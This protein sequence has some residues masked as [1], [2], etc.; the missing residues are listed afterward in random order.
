[1]KCLI[2]SDIHYDL[3]HFDWLAE[4]ASDYDVLIIAG[5]LLD[6]SSPVPPQ[7]Q[8]S[9]V[10]SYLSE[11]KDQTTLIVSS[12]NH[13]LNSR[14][15]NGEKYSKWFSEL[16]KM[17]IVSDGDFYLNETVL[18]TV[19]PWW[20]GPEVKNK[21]ITQLENDSKK[22]R[23]KWIWIY[24]PPPSD[25]PTSW[26]GRR[27]YGDDDLLDWIEK[28]CPDIVLGGHIHQAPFSEDGSWVDQVGSTL[29]FNP[30]KQIGP[31]P[32]HIILD[33]KHTEAVWFSIYEN[34]I[35][36]LD[37]SSKFMVADLE[38]LPDWLN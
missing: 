4:V 33:T 7:T 10:L 31:Y 34:K 13:D 12:G 29:F 21:I 38:K 28:Y 22:E 23:E 3:Q 5:D 36:R 2:V 9:V 27:H 37:S 1:M 32:T 35:V 17:G 11:I 8:I 20:D 6:V 15:E 18:F 25:S 16:K 30:G 19:Y 26:N 24:H 14:N